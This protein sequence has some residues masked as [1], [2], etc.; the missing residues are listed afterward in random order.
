MK[1]GLHG[2]R[3][4]AAWVSWAVASVV[5][6]AVAPVAHAQSGV[7]QSNEHLLKYLEVP[8]DGRMWRTGPSGFVQRELWRL[9][10][11]ELAS[12]GRSRAWGNYVR[13]STTSGD[14]GD[15]L[16]GVAD[17]V[18]GYSQPLNIGLLESPQPG[19][20]LPVDTTLAADTLALVPANA[21]M[22]STSWQGL[23][24]ATLHGQVDLVTGV[25]LTR[26]TDLVLPFNGS[27][28]RLVR[29]RASERDFGKW[30]RDKAR[31]PY[32]QSR[33]WDWVGEG[34]MMSEN[35]LLI[36][37]STA[38]D[39]VG[40]GTPRVWLW[41][42]A[43]R[44]IPFDWIAEGGAGLGR[45]DCA[46]R[47]RAK[48]TVSRSDGERPRRK[49]NAT[50]TAAFDD[51]GNGQ[52]EPGLEPDKFTIELYDGEIVMEFTPVW[53]DVPKWKYRWMG[54]PVF[55]EHERPV[56]WTSL[57][58]RPMLPQGSTEEDTVV[59]ST[60]LRWSCWNLWTQNILPHDWNPTSATE[61]NSRG[62]GM[63][64]Y[65]LLT[66]IRDRFGNRAEMT[67]AP[68]TEW[69]ASNSLF[70]ASE[71]ARPVQTSLQKGMLTEVRLVS[72]T[73]AAPLVHWTLVYGYRLLPRVEE[74]VWPI[75]TTH[76]WWDTTGPSSGNRL[77]SA[78]RIAASDPVLESVYVFEGDVKTRG[79]VLLRLPGE[80]RIE[81]DFSASPDESV[82]WP[83]TDVNDL[84]KLY[85]EGQTAS[86]RLPSA[87]EG[88][89]SSAERLESLTGPSWS[90]RL[91]YDHRLTRET[92]IDTE[93]EVETTGYR[94]VARPA[95]LCRVRTDVRSS[96]S[97]EWTTRR[98][99]IFQYEQTPHPTRSFGLQRAFTD[100]GIA[101]ACSMLAH[102]PADFEDRCRYLANMTEVPGDVP[103]NWRIKDSFTQARYGSWDFNNAATVSFET[104]E[105]TPIIGGAAL[106]ADRILEGES[107]SYSFDDRVSTVSRVSLVDESG[108]RRHYRITRL[109]R[110]PAAFGGGS[111][112][113]PQIP[114]SAT[115]MRSV[116]I[117][118]FVWQRFA[119]SGATYS[120]DGIPRT[121]WPTLPPASNGA[122]A[123]FTW[124]TGSQSVDS[125]ASFAVKY[126]EA[127]WISIIDE[128]PTREAAD[129][130]AMK[131]VVSL[132]GGS[133]KV[134]F[135]GRSIARRIVGINPLG[136]VLW[137][138]QFDL[139]WPDSQS[140]RFTESGSLGLTERYIYET[141]HQLLTRLKDA[142]T[143]DGAPESLRTELYLTERRTAGWSA[144]PADSE[145]IKT[146]GLIE[147]FD[148]TVLDE[149]DL[150]PGEEGPT[151]SERL[152]LHA[153]GLQKGDSVDSVLDRVWKSQTF[154]DRR[155]PSV[156]RGQVQFSS[157]NAALFDSS[158]DDWSAIELR[159]DAP[160]VSR[161]SE[162]KTEADGRTTRLEY[163][164]VSPAQQP[165]PTGTANVYD[166]SISVTG[167]DGLTPW[168]IS[169][170]VADPDS[171][172]RQ[173]SD[174]VRLDYTEYDSLG[175]VVHS[176]IDVDPSSPPMADPDRSASFTAACGLLPV[177]YNTR[178]SPS[179]TAAFH[180]EQVY[181]GEG[182]SDTIYPSGKRSARRAV[183]I[184]AVDDPDLLGISPALIDFPPPIGNDEPYPAIRRV[185]EFPV[186]VPLGDG[187]FEAAGP[188]TI[189]EFKKWENPHTYWMPHLNSNDLHGSR[190][191][192]DH[193]AK[194]GQPS[195]QMIRER[196][197]RFNTPIRLGYLDVKRITTA[198]FE[199]A[200]GVEYGYDAM[201]RINRVKDLEFGADCRFAA[202]AELLDNGDT[203]RVDAMDGNKFYSIRN[204]RGQI[205]RE[206]AGT[207][208]LLWN[209][210]AIEYPTLAP[211]GTSFD[212][213]LR[214]R[215]EFG[216]GSNDARLP[217]RRWTYLEPPTSWTSEQLAPFGPPPADDDEGEL[218]QT[219]YDWRMRPVRV[220]VFGPKSSGVS[221]RP[222]LSTRVTYLDHADRVRFEAVFGSGVVP[223]LGAHDPTTLGPKAAMPTAAQILAAGPTS[224]VETVY[225]PG[226]AVK[227]R[228]TYRT[229]L[230]GSPASAAQY[231]A[232]RF[233]YGPGG[234]QVYAERPNA[235]VQITTVD[236]LGRVHRE[237][238]VAG[239]NEQS[240]TDSLYDSDANVIIT[241]R[242]ERLP[243]TS[244][245]DLS[246]TNA[247][248]SRTETWHD[249][250]RRP[251]A[252]LE[253]GTGAATFS[254]G[255]LPAL[256]SNASLAARLTTAPRL[257]VLGS[258]A[259]RTFL[260]STGSAAAAVSEGG[261]LTVH[262][263]DNAGN[264][265]ATRR[266]DGVVTVFEYDKKNRLTSQIEDYCTLAAA[267]TE[268]QSG[269]PGA[270]RETRNHYWLG[271]TIA[272]SSR[273]VAS[274]ATT[275]QFQ[276]V[277]YG[278]QLV[279][280]FNAEFDIDP[281]SAT[282]MRAFPD[283]EHISN[284]SALVA[285]MMSINPDSTPGTPLMGQPDTVFTKPDMI[286]RYYTDGLIAE[287]I[288]RRGVAMRYYYD[289]LRRLVAT[290]VWHYPLVASET[291]SH[292]LAGVALV[293]PLSTYEECPG[294]TGSG[295]ENPAPVGTPQ[296]LPGYP[297]S[298]T[299]PGASPPE[300]RVGYIAYEYDARGNLKLVT[301]RTGRH[302][303]A[304]ITQT[305]YE[306]DERN[307]LTKEWQAHGTLT[308]ATGVPFVTYS[309][310]YTAATPTT[311]GQDRL[312]S[313]TYPTLDPAVPA[314]VIT[315]AYGA[316]NSGDDAAARITAI[317]K[318]S[319]AIASFSYTGAGRRVSLG[320]GG[321]ATAPIIRQTFDTQTGGG[322][323]GLDRFGRVRDLHYITTNAT[324]NT[325][326]RGEYAYDAAGNRLS[327]RLTQR[328]PGS[329]GGGG[330]TGVN[331]R[332]RA[333]TYDRLDRLTG[334][335]SGV[336][337]AGTI[338]TKSREESWLLDQL[339][340][341]AGVNAQPMPRS[342][343]CNNTVPGGGPGGEENGGGPGGGGVQSP[344]PYVAGHTVDEYNATGV[345][346]RVLS[347]AHRV[348]DPGREAT[349]H[350]YDGAA[351]L[352]KQRSLNSIRDIHRKHDEGD[353]E[354]TPLEHDA[355]GNQTWDGTYFYQYD[356]W[357]RLVQVN[358]ATQLH[359][360]WFAADGMF[361]LRPTGAQYLPTCPN[362]QL[363]WVIKHHTYD[364]VGR[365]VRTTSR[366]NPGDLSEGYAYAG[367]GGP[368]AVVNRSERY[369]YDGV[370]RIQEIVT[371]PVVVN[372][373]DGDVSTMQEEN[374]LTQG[375]NG[376]GG[377]S[378][379]LPSPSFTVTYCRAENVWGPGDNGVDE[380]LAQYDRDAKPW[381]AAF[382]AQSDLVALLH[383]PTG[384][385][386]AE[387]A[388][389]WT[390]SPYGQVLTYEQFH[391]HPVVTH[392]H[393]GLA[394]DRLDA[395]ALTWDTATSA[396]SDTPRL[397]PGAR[398]L[399]HAR[400]RTLDIERGRW[401]QSDPNA[402][403]VVLESLPRYHGS[404]MT[405]S[406]DTIDLQF[407]SGDGGNLAFYARSNPAAFSDPMGLFVGFIGGLGGATSLTDLQADW[408]Q[409]VA[410]A[411]NTVRESM[412]GMFESVAMRQF[413]DALWAL[414]WS[415][416][417]DG[418]WASGSVGQREQAEI[419][420]DVGPAMAG[421][422]RWHHI[423]T[424]KNKKRGG[425]WTLKFN[426]ILDGTGVSLNDRANLFE[427]TKEWSKKYHSHGAHSQKY[428]ADVFTML[429]EAKTKW[430]KA[431]FTGAE[432]G[433]M[434]RYEMIKIGDKIAANGR[435][436]RDG[437]G[438]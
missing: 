386:P 431:G 189:R 118:P 79:A 44:S 155:N 405:A 22:V 220:E 437:F 131:P 387:V 292:P 146:D 51:I 286:F 47:Y 318:G 308:T 200:P 90:F 33:Y 8:G 322:L 133:S 228:R 282:Q 103:E 176:W 422:A 396:I 397:M 380:L 346:T 151:L 379:Q 186:L 80:S 393:K 222:R 53:Q 307:N 13:Q 144:A 1:S 335:T 179:A 250:A 28:F 110:L 317:T 203:V 69:S 149:P 337:S 257:K 73:E 108:T 78:E 35:P 435:V 119:S 398:L 350:T 167:S 295:F 414:D 374:Q 20:F 253:Y 301:A 29:T 381:Y 130:P 192:V 89:G 88:S 87:G 111:S 164:S 81:Q 26:F 419:A 236:N 102:A 259:A 409:N 403:G 432:L 268:E 371:D 370:R 64:Y 240:R 420:Q 227:E 313:M 305:K 10:N 263:Y 412:T 310:T 410:D 366:L 61:I 244:G 163:R 332:S 373:G 372:N 351:Y 338:V 188:C 254:N 319:S 58:E 434:L 25:P 362:P 45:Y 316:A 353:D 241:D 247:V 256:P 399:A 94:A 331:E 48:L 105:S 95:L 156:V 37:D 299:P 124:K 324:P 275:E 92:I 38:A 86:I 232:E 97:A 354:W 367:A 273:R 16:S 242:Y 233:G 306:Y 270:R 66:R 138:K 225:F 96:P 128:F 334:V 343:P 18:P 382:D 49:V 9:P 145:G 196:V 199:V 160:I 411:S 193:G 99:L 178:S 407:R 177:G 174:L 417:D 357:N 148:Y 152:K 274:D 426:S 210:G 132:S 224:L 113:H 201:G 191:R 288:D 246:A 235:P 269:T 82:F 122:G 415:E 340:N 23:S 12:D 55:P 311:T 291:S 41:L 363:G 168:S 436:L 57:H 280:P 433:V 52:W 185:F 258:G 135:L 267:S 65:G 384:T 375:T 4:W 126:D 406:T 383:Q 400:N 104:S 127:R 170:T 121:E 5:A 27:Q 134:S 423:A 175:R 323:E 359:W 153:I 123:S 30:S 59:L 237:I 296:A 330:L 355:N 143:A 289:D 342:D 180:T 344:P 298:M 336:L 198:M 284:D 421:I 252:T 212:I 112:I 290:E 62:L 438:L 303:T 194:W 424:N 329:G 325:L 239:A 312:V 413:E 430:E 404:S 68:V 139:V 271:R 245:A 6:G 369:L 279:A 106:A 115:P 173:P 70:G 169:A 77:T 202:R 285:M 43:F 214:S 183:T 408:T 261:L 34:W 364:G 376:G 157:P 161:S 142:A 294:G 181:D 171:A 136:H 109:V 15:I 238:M 283:L 425:A 140:G 314:T 427:M 249:V 349:N 402:S 226:G 278:A 266:P 221:A 223:N 309:R 377:E 101:A 328:T 147:I 46:P 54:P 293:A 166:V 219:A 205:S 116:F 262:A 206:Y 83:R 326:W 230:S 213:T 215:S 85:R 345:A 218:T 392:G 63:A 234:T 391:P 321:T 21:A 216:V 287:R 150:G 315:F 388:G 394:I 154:F 395:P 182:L 418:A 100:D 390:Y 40:E 211:S 31:H 300:D 190:F 195:W 165:R 19:D 11:G 84:L 76:A 98:N 7:M 159:S 365:L 327:E 217:V 117:S 207:R 187:S 265:V 243:G 74:S 162:I 36:I 60:L 320:L 231:V 251:I 264:K 277:A 260:F 75:G 91:R 32:A 208:D 281:G 368:Y 360:F 158:E 93:T 2:V 361:K 347:E 304:I 229:A 17:E 172:T 114:A 125:I 348:I 24:R 428:H 14:Q 120:N 204:S 356:A 339:G 67:Y 141:G 42:D 416:P 3:R 197:V 276:G 358:A 352:E 255:T 302:A 378:G 39:H 137:E 333:F 209:A 385:N 401:L 56:Q 107:S 272:V 129:S 184:S 389:Q 71:P 50:S 248:I 297:A 429:S 341:W 72:G